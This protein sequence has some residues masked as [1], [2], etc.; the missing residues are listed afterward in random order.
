MLVV[1]LSFPPFPL[2]AVDVFS[3]TRYSCDLLLV[4]HFKI[5]TPPSMYSQLHS[6][7]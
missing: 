6:Q 3:F 4:G 7:V 2:T 5:T 1:R